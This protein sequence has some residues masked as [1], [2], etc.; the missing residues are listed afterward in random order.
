MHNINDKTLGERSTLLIL[1]DYC[2]MK[3]FEYVELT[4]YVNLY[5]TCHRLRDVCDIVCSKKYKKIELGTRNYD[6]YSNKKI[7]KQEFSDALSVIGRH[8]LAIE[9]GQARQVIL[10]IIVENCKNLKS[11]KMWRGKSALKLQKFRNLKEFRMVSCPKRAMMN[12][13]EWR[14]FITNN[15]ELESLECTQCYEEDIMELMKLL[16]ALKRL[17]FIYG[18][19]ADFHLTQACQNVLNLDGLTKLVFF[20]DMNCNQILIEL[21]KKMNLVE[22]DVLMDFNAESLQIIKTFR[23]LEVLSISNFYVAF[24]AE[25]FL[26]ASV[27]PPK[28]KCIKIDGIKMSCTTFLSIVKR[29]KFLD[30]F[31]LK[32]SG[33]FLDGDRC[34][35]LY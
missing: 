34:K 27:F 33:V 24:Q 11:L 22:L 31:D 4:D 26:G 25:W 15:P 35:L 3:I 32:N 13:A 5:K 20:S 18:T 2:L 6:N 17:H 10:D 19:S 12:T 9:I 30:E 1:N 23:D 29:L 14:S 7:S 21:A 28:L 8:V 16:P